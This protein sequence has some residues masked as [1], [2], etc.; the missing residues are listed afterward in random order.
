[1][2]RLISEIDNTPSYILPGRVAVKGI[3]KKTRMENE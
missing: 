2:L 1:M 3:N